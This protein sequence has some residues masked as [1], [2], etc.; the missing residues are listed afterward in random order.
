MQAADAKRPQQWWIPPCGQLHSR[1][2]NQERS[3]NTATSWIMKQVIAHRIPQL[4]QKGRSRHP[5]DTGSV[6][7][8]RWYASTISLVNAGEEPGADFI[9]CVSGVK[10]T[11]PDIDAPTPSPTP[12]RTGCTIPVKGEWGTSE[13]KFLKPCTSRHDSYHRSNPQE[14]SV[15]VEQHPTLSLPNI[16]NQTTSSMTHLEKD[17]D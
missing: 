17:P 2:Q 8:Q 9:T 1:R 5:R 3:V 10:P 13:H 6:K 4:E 16:Y 12:E 11:T 7:S 14:K 15:V